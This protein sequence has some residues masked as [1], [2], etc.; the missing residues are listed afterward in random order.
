MF[1]LMSRTVEHRIVT[2]NSVN[3]AVFLKFVTFRDV[4][5]VY[6]VSLH[7]DMAGRKRSVITLAMYLH[8]IWC[9]QEV[10]NDQLTDYV[11]LLCGETW[12]M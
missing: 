7:V 10:W 2:G 9:I 4:I 1:L 3:Q 8:A 12:F 6:I 5:G 11:P